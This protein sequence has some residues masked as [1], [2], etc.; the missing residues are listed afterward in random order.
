MYLCLRRLSSASASAEGHPCSSSVSASSVRSL[1]RAVIVHT[2]LRNAYINEAWRRTIIQRHI[3]CSPLHSFIPA[4]LASLS[5]DSFI[6]VDDRSAS[7]RSEDNVRHGAPLATTSLC[8]ASHPEVEECDNT[9]ETTS[10]AARSNADDGYLMGL[11]LHVWPALHTFR[12]SI[13]A[14][15]G[16]EVRFD[17][18][19][20]YIG[21]TEAERPE[22]ATLSENA[23]ARACSMPH[24][25]TWLKG[26]GVHRMTNVRDAAFIGCM[27]EI[28]PSHA[29]AV[30]EAWGRLQAVAA[31][32]L[33]DADARVM[34]REAEA[35]SGSQK[36]LAAFLDKANNNSNWLHDEL[37]NTSVDHP[38]THVRAWPALNR[39]R[40][41]HPSCLVRDA[42]R[43]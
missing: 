32:H 22:A 40:I 29:S 31:G 1:A 34:E 43:F 8:V 25:P 17:K 28:L 19:H 13:K 36:E 35:A 10:G 33:S 4:L 37:Y 30:R 11:P 20:V 7:L 3:D 5:T 9:L 38:R 15:V 12:T 21:D 42:G 18:M 39:A 26:A 24:L 23:L 41:T 2:D 16:L 6:L 14:F 27:N